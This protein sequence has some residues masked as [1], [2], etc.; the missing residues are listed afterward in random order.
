MAG[1]G[2]AWR[3]VAGCGGAWLRG[4]GR[5]GARAQLLVGGSGLGE[6]EAVEERGEGADEWGKKQGDEVDHLKASPSALF[7]WRMKGVKTL[8][9]LE[10]RLLAMA[11]FA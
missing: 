7:T 6:P 10:R 1:R 11:L 3:G 4:A 9:P 5:G 8:G 2:G